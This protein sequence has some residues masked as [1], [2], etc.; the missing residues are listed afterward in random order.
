MTSQDKW[1]HDS[2]PATAIIGGGMVGLTLAVGLASAGLPVTVVERDD[3]ALWT[4]EGF[5]GRA[6][7]IAAGSR[8]VFET[9]GVWPSMAPYGEAILD[10]RITDGLAPVYLHFDHGELD[11]GPLGHM[12]E[13][14][15]I[16]GALMEA[17]MA[18]PSINFVAP[19]N[20]AAMTR[21]ATGIE[22]ALDDGT[23]IETP[24]L[25]GSDGRGSR[26]REWAGINQTQWRYSQAAIVTTVTHDQPHDGIAEERFLPAG[27]FAILPMTDDEQSRHRSSIVWTEREDL[28]PAY[29]G[30]SDADFNA[31]LGARF[32]DHLGM[33]T[34]IGPRWSYPL[35]LSLAESY[36]ADRLALIGDAAHGIHPIAGQGLN[37]GIRDAAALA[38]TIVD[39][40]RLGLDYGMKTVL[41]D[42]QRWRRF[43][44]VTLAGATDILNRLFSTDWVPLRAARGLG[45]ALVNRIGPVRRLFMREAMGLTGDLPRL[46]R[47]EAL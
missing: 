30:L 46:V 19:H 40:G 45:L 38:E 9:L 28:V 24:L 31:E 42:Y 2:G 29:L 8:R 47:G 3:P 20:V 35:G 41:E 44:N 12:V 26:V 21:T 33:V 15:V 1:T 23:V 22:L 37:L 14:R 16:R 34:A 4:D 36:I 25:V 17:V 7:A 5:D 32:G 27:P 43:D 18:C 39:A 10:I 6:S 11:E 13:N